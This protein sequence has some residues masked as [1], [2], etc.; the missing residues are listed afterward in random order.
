MRVIEPE[1]VAAE[2]DSVPSPSGRGLG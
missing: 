2:S 1:L